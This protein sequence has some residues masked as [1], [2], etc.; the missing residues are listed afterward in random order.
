M[1][2]F[3][4]RLQQAARGKEIFGK[5]FDVDKLS[6]EDTFLL[7]L[8]DNEEC[9]RYGFKYLPDFIELYQRRD[10]YI[11]LDDIRLSDFFS[12]AGGKVKLCGGKELQYLA[13]YLNIFHNKEGLDTRIIFLTEKEG[14]SL[15]IKELLQRKVFTLEEYVAISLYQLEKLKEV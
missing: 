1:K 2:K 14:Y 9:I 5:M 12:R 15:S 3:E 11:L 13:A 8:T 6:L 4:E 10:V 7:V